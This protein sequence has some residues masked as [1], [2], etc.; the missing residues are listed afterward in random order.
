MSSKKIKFFFILPILLL[1]LLFISTLALNALIQNPT[2]QNYLLARLGASIGY[3]LKA[4][5]MKFDFA[6]GLRAYVHDLSAKQKSGTGKFTAASLYLILDAGEIIRGRIIP[7][8]FLLFKP[9]IELSLTESRHTPRKLEFDALM[10]YPL[11]KILGKIDYAA[12][13]AATIVLKNQDIKLDNLFLQLSPQ[14]HNKNL[15][16]V[17]MYGS[18]EFKKEKSCFFTKGKIDLYRSG[19]KETMAA[20]A[21]K[22]KELPLGWAPTPRSLPVRKGKAD[23]K[24]NL[25][26]MRSGSIF[27][28]G[29]LLVDDLYFLAENPKGVKKYY[30]PEATVDLKADYIKN[31][32]NISS[33]NLKTDNYTL[34]ASAMFDLHNKSDPYLDL[35]VSSPFMPLAYF[36]EVFPTPLVSHWLEETLYPCFKKGDVRFDLFA[37]QG[38]FSRLAHLNKHENASCL[39]L[40]LS[41][42]NLE[43]ITNKAALPYT[44][45]SGRLLIKD[46]SLAVSNVKGIFGTSVVT[47]G[48]MNIDNLYSE[49][50]LFN[51]Y[52]K[53]QCTLED[54]KQQAES[55]PLPEHIQTRI[56][57]IT[58]LSGKV[59]AELTCEHIRDWKNLELKKSV[60]KLKDCFITA[61]EL[62]LPLLIAE[63]NFHLEDNENSNFYAKGMMGKSFFILSGQGA[64]ICKKGNADISFSADINEIL[65]KTTKVYNKII[66]FNNIIPGRASI[67]WKDDGVWSCEGEIN[68]E[69]VEKYESGF[70][71]LNRKLGEKIS[72]NLDVIPGQKIIV[73][74]ISANPGKTS[75]ALSGSFDLKDMDASSLKVMAEPLHLEDVKFL[76]HGFEKPPAG[77]IKCSVEIKRFVSN[78]SKTQIFGKCAAHDISFSKCD[79][80]FEI[81]ACNFQAEFSGQEILISSFESMLGNSSV[82]LN[83]STL[84]GWNGIKGEINIEAGYLDLAGLI[85]GG[86]NE[87]QKNE[88][89][90][91]AD[92]IK[93]S[94]LK[95]NIKSNKGSWKQ[96]DY[97]RLSAEIAFRD[98]LIHVENCDI[99]NAT[100]NLKIIGHINS[101]KN[102]ESILNIYAK[103]DEYPTENIIQSLDILTDIN[104]AGAAL[105]T[106]GYVSIKGFD[107]K[108]IISNLTGNFNMLLKDGVVK[109]SNIIFTVL[110]F[111]SLN[112]IVDKKP[113]DFSEKGFNFNSIKGNL[114][115]EGGVLKTDNLVMQSPIFNM[116]GNG[117]LDLNNEKI[118]LN[119]VISP[120]GTIDL[121]INKIPVVG[122]VLTGKEKSIITFY[123]KVQGSQS[124]PEIKYIPF[125]HWPASIFGFVKRTFMTPG[126]WF[127]DMRKV[128]KD[129]SDKGF[130][131]PE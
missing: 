39:L 10:R 55:A 110:N 117:Y 131:L 5:Y 12:I 31:I 34:H 49:T 25:Q 127:R 19:N 86:N 111:L 58:S 118:D 29:R 73:N 52:L 17:D 105:S 11:F 128:K 42:N 50:A 46:G 102:S 122:Y 13:S 81:K 90:D 6:G 130:T 123:L 8:K 104:V 15:L 93:N 62:K 103:L 53:A 20:L 16:N 18:I 66:N 64:G 125:Q 85:A 59:N 23:A 21:L 36:K 40:E 38:S 126:R 120:L 33:F 75:I 107:K 116:A 67:K 100:G 78:L 129:Y 24:I 80:P 3:E 68:P 54:I 1:L 74:K 97:N 65:Q 51:Y 95:L 9:E 45:T 89:K 70:S 98:S 114:D 106:E 22:I 84:H 72:F 30:L 121:L 7:K 101:E 32:F 96:I 26:I 37:L 57:K 27:I 119:L 60:F 63:A 14:E 71:T 43:I 79:L 99:Q 28:N 109:K 69:G 35:K 56:Q 77:T 83:N 44:G 76:F 112:N 91:L 82:S 4:G 48:S 2:V 47:D 115:I 92:F 41:L 124:K 94:D 61:P 113:S 88:K 108:D 87:C